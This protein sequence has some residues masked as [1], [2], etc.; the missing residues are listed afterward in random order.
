MIRSRIATSALKGGALSILAFAMLAL[1]SLSFAESAVPLHTAGTYALLAGTPLISNTGPSVI[2]GDVGISP[3][4]S[5]TGF[6]GAPNGTVN[7]SIL[8][9]AAVSGAKDDL[10]TAFIDASGRAGTP[11][12]SDQLAGVTLT[13]GVYDGGALD[14]SVGGVLTLDGQ[15]DPNAVFIIRAASSLV[16]GSGSSVLLTRGAQSCNVFWVVGSSASFGTT[17][18]FVGNVLAL[19]SIT[20]LAGTQVDGRLLARNGQIMLDTTNVTRPQC[21]AVVSPPPGGDGGGVVVPPPG[22][23]SGVITPPGGVVIPPG[24]VAPPGGVVPP[25]VGGGVI[26]PTTPLDVVRPTVAFTVPHDCVEVSF[27]T[28]ITIRDASSLR[29]AHVYVDGRLVAK[30]G[31][32]VSRIKILVRGLNAG[33]HRLRVTVV[34]RRGNMRSVVKKFRRCEH[35]NAVP[36]FTG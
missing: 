36:H 28:R 6:G 7:G 9:G 1:P 2:T 22:G 14:L 8:A 32:G 11:L 12:A 34:D 17:T 23:G 26:S 31:K 35:V 29:F 21:A 4:L 24:G 25:V 19:T 27:V 15:N 13:T 20:S 10:T 16:T 18:N 5:V 3:A 33:T 30:V